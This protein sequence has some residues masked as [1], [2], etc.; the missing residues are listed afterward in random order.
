MQPYL[1]GDSSID[2][3]L[4]FKMCNCVLTF[5]IKSFFTKSIFLPVEL[6]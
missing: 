2:T 1:E 3:N 6:V 4:V 5:A